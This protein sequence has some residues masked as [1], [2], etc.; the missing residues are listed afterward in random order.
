MNKQ[1]GIAVFAADS[2]STIHCINHITGA[3]RDFVFFAP[4]QTAVLRCKTRRL[5]LP[6]ASDREPKLPTSIP[7]AQRRSKTWPLQLR[8]TTLRTAFACKVPRLFAASGH[9]DGSSFITHTAQRIL[10]LVMMLLCIYFTV[11]IPS[12][13]TANRSIPA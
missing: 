1:I 7:Y 10:R 11:L 5:W 9:Q 12:H 8:L 3:A 6:S 4:S 13:R 2:D